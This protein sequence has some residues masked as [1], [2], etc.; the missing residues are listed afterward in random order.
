M[1]AAFITGLAGPA[2][3][4]NEAGFLKSSRPCGI[5]LFARNIQNPDQVRRLVNDVR[6]AVGSARV[7][8]LVDQEGGRVQRLR[9]PH[10]R[11]LPSAAAY[12]R[13]YAANPEMALAAARQVARLTAADL[14]ALGINTNCAPVLDVPVF[15]SHDVIGDRAYGSTVEQVVALGRAVAEGLVSG[16]VLPV[17][18]HIP[19][20]GRATVDSHFQLP[21]VTAT[22]AELVR[23]D[24]AAFRGLA[25]MPAAMSAHVVFTELDSIPASISGVLISQVVRG[26]IGFDGLLISDDLSMKA[27][28]GGLRA[29][30]EAVI[31]AGG[32]VALHCNGDLLEMQAVAEGV[33]C[34]TQVSKVRFERALQAP[35][36]SEDFDPIEAEA[37][38]EEVLRL[39]A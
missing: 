21:I 12:A 14:A 32:D 37:C 30:A 11:M 17:I 27:L 31:C 3:S 16:G 23:T 15:G 1:S 28:S 8:V 4:P 29:R 18:K 19:G 36:Q 2:L 5:I 20:H 25:D 39:S 38:L 10:W 7:L 22:H 9:P 35:Q 26:S 13:L 33:P 6:A 34:L 24:F